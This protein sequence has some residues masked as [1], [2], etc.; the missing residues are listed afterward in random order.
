[1]IH[2][3]LADDH[4]IVRHGLK[5]LLA[6]ELPEARFGEAGT[7]AEALA[8]LRRRAWH[9][10][11]LDLNMPGRN[12]FEVLEETRRHFPGLAILVLSST[13]EDQVGVSVLKAGAAG[14]LNKQTAPERLVEAVR[15]V[16]RGEQYMSAA[17]AQRL[18]A[19]L[20]RGSDRPRH[21]MLSA[22]E[23]QVCLL[24]AAGRSLKEISAELA[25]SPKTVSTFHTRA[26]AKLG[27]GNDAELANYVRDHRMADTG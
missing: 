17:L 24:T 19:D 6:D 4:A 12:G 2:I 3:L 13:P 27:V 1:M 18:V 16:L 8:L 22:R 9:V 20:R 10:L 15:T 23:R 5:Q 7:S 25:L 14:Y 11:I 21:E 26:F